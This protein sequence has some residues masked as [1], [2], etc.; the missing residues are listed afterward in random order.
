MLNVLIYGTGPY[1]KEFMKQID[2]T[3]CNILA[4]VDREIKEAQFDGY[5]VISR[6]EIKKQE[7]DYLIIAATHKEIYKILIEEYHVSAQ[8]VI[9]YY[10]RGRQETIKENIL[11]R[12]LLNRLN[13]VEFRLEEY[14]ENNDYV[15]TKTIVNICSILKREQREG[16]IC[17]LGLVNSTV[18]NLLSNIL[19]K[20]VQVLHTIDDCFYGE[21][22]TSQQKEFAEELWRNNQDDIA[23][24]TKNVM[25]K[26]LYPDKLDYVVGFREEIYS[27]IGENISFVYIEC[28]DARLLNSH[29]ETVYNKVQKRG[30]IF[31]EAASEGILSPLFVKAIKENYMDLLECPIQ[32]EKTSILFIKS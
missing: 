12:I 20:A 6:E 28:G 1:A 8:K 9:P 19:G 23:Y 15:F 29:L 32:R 7:F 25:E 21:F 2:K 3:R 14:C 10:Y 18:V 4:F 31:V 17:T 5:P 26:I 27:R 24:S 22:T 13:D 16:T 30:Y 11:N